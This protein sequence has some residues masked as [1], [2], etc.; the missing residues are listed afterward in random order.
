MIIQIDTVDNVHRISNLVSIRRLIRR[1]IWL[2]KGLF[3]NNW[4]LPALM[5]CVLVLIT[6]MIIHDYRISISNRT[7]LLNHKIA[8]TI[9]RFR[10]SA[11]ESVNPSQS[12]ENVITVLAWTFQLFEYF[13]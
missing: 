2:P 9:Y 5:K 7:S 4:S 8:D 1:I 11:Y 13:A 3:L 6:F 10:E 12:L